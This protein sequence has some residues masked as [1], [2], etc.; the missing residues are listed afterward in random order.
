MG[1]RNPG[2]RHETR[3][4]KHTENQ[5]AEWR[6][7]IGAIH[8]SPDFLSITNSPTQRKVV[9]CPGVGQSEYPQ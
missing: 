4:K 8:C 6:S 9:L 7:A 3:A 5:G 1:R 2:P